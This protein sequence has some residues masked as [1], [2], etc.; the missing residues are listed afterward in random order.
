MI[1]VIDLLLKNLY[2]KIPAE[3]LDLAF[4]REGL[5]MDAVI[6]DQVIVNVVLTQANLYSGRPKRITLLA[7][8]SKN[9]EEPTRMAMLAGDY[10][11][12]QIPE[13]AREYRD[14]N[15][16][17]DISY[18]V[19]M[20]FQGQYPY[21][22][23]S[24]SRSVMSTAEDAMSSMTRGPSTSTPQVVLM[25]NNIIKLLHPMAAHIDWSC[26]VWL[27]MD[28]NMSNVSPNMI[29]PLQD[30]TL[31]ATQMVIWNKLSIR[32][33]QGMLVGGQ[34][35]DA[36]KMIVDQ[37]EGAEERF[38]AALMKMRGASVLQPNELPHLLASMI[39]G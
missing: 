25:G 31:Y 17:I 8:Y 4:S 36:V 3:I 27:A 21:T 22:Q 37:Y 2:V 28:E 35:L 26:L 33:N 38:D 20:A 9:L 23:P 34:T 11:V 7:E 39:G 6:R 32:L 29:R 14:I 19:L 13:E 12:Y 5:S 16:V 1:N 15:A 30:M 18:P 10:S 24:G